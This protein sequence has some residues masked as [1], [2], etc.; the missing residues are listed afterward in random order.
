MKFSIKDFFSKKDQIPSFLWIWSHLLRKSLMEKFILCA[1]YINPLQV[2]V[3]FLHP[4][5]TFEFFIFSGGVE[6]KYLTKLD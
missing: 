4:L 1:V 2:N 3:S 6:R 5:K